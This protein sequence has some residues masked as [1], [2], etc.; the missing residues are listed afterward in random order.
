[1]DLFDLSDKTAVVTGGNSG[2]GYAIAEGLARHG[3]RVVIV[4]R[5]EA[6]GSMAAE[7]IVAQGFAAEAIPADVSRAESVARVVASVI[8]RHG[9]IDILV[10][11][12][13]VI[14][15]KPAEELTED[16]WDLVMNVNLRGAF[17]C[18]R[19]VGRHMISRQQG[20]IINV[21]SNVSEVVQSLRSVYCV[22]K[23]GLSHLTRALALEWAPHH[24]TVNAIG[25]GPTMTELNRRY[26]EEHPDDLR[27]RIGT[28][29]MAR[30]GAPWDHVG[31]AIF[32]ASAA[33]DYVTGQTLIVD[34]GLNLS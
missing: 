13:A 12:A 15:R 11:S 30:I 6:H 27:Q 29:P 16:E 26:F 17:L 24:V 8:E 14:V 20:K 7:R 34:G 21:S 25:P 10:N 1:M 3:A 18:C 28:I 32:L 9:A 23:A 33:S 5:R 19:D 31:A 22:S 4:N 2:I